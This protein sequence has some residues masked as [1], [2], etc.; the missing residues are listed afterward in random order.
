MRA[1]ALEKILAF[2]VAANLGWVIYRFSV[3][4]L[5]LFGPSLLERLNAGLI[6]ALAVFALVRVLRGRIRGSWVC[7]FFYAL[8]IPQFHPRLPWIWLNFG[9]NPLVFSEAGG[10]Q[11][12]NFSWTAALL[13]VFAGYVVWVRYRRE[14]AAD[15]A[16]LAAGE[17]PDLTHPQ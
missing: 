12:Y 1:T 7:L 4:G 11:R 8:Q 9:Y 3:R 5:A 15:E 6:F 2:T 14:R 16:A 13:T 10:P 17:S